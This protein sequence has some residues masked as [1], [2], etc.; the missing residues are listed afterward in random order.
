M[1]KKE[2]M[3]SKNYQIASAYL[4]LEQLSDEFGQE[5]KSIMSAVVANSEVNGFPHDNWKKKLLESI[6]VN[7]SFEIFGK[8]FGFVNLNDASALLDELCI[9]DVY[10]LQA[11][12]SLKKVIDIG[13]SNGFF[14]F[15]VLK[16][17]KGVYVVCVE[18]NP[19]NVELLNSNLYSFKESGRIQIIPKALHKKSTKTRLKIASD[20]NVWG[21]LGAT[22]VNR[23]R[24]SSRDLKSLTVDSLTLQ[25]L[26]IDTVDLL[27]VDIEGLE[28]QAIPVAGEKIKNCKVVMVEVHADVN[29]FEEEFLRLL[30]F[31]KNNGFTYSIYD[32]VKSSTGYIVNKPSPSFMLCAKNTAHFVK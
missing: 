1:K 14:A 8:R 23:V 13:A 24:T 29:N 3:H 30:R 12:D 7:H 9:N 18:P 31:F 16:R 22:V 5:Q 20:T 4:W 32:G 25:E 28:F 10:G 17:F 2:P 21:G 26:L 19:Q 15:N 27:K 6:S 11:F